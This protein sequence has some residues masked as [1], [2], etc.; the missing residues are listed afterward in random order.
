MYIAIVKSEADISLSWYNVRM[1]TVLPRNFKRWLTVTRH[2][3]GTVL[4]GDHL[5]LT[6]TVSLSN[7][8]PL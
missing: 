2:V 8:S 6:A 7:G 5:F 4:A 3:F 1:Y